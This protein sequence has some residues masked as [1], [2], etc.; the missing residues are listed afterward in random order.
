MYKPY[1]LIHVTMISILH[2]IL[3][4]NLLTTAVKF[5]TRRL[6]STERML[7][8]KSIPLLAPNDTYYNLEKGALVKKE[9]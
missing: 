5:I 1:A 4:P 6:P 8:V 3:H 9:G 7:Q 2:M